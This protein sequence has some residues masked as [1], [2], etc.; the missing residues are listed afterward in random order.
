MSS[1]GETEAAPEQSATERAEFQEQTRAHRLIAW[2]E[3][4]GFKVPRKAQPVLDDRY[5]RP[6][7][8]RE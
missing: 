6:L 7:E 5:D 3:G 8:S 1:T 4:Q 2:R